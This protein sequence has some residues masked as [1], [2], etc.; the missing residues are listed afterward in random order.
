[1]TVLPFGGDR[2]DG[3]ASN[4]PA[5]VLQAELEI[6]AQLLRH[7]ARTHARARFCLCL[8][9]IATERLGG[10]AAVRQVARHLDLMEPV[11]LVTDLVRPTELVLTPA[12]AIV[13]CHYV[14]RCSRIDLHHPAPISGP[15]AGVV[16]FVEFSPRSRAR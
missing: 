11:R 10:L 16:K 3:D 1:S 8:L 5:R 9:G 7:D 14:L 15:A 4:H 2:F 6:E 13:A 12:L